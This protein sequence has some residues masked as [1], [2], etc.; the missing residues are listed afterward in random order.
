MMKG[1]CRMSSLP[2]HVP[3]AA[4]PTSHCKNR[5]HASTGCREV[6][7]PK[8]TFKASVTIQVQRLQEGSDADS[9]TVARPLRTGLFHPW[10]TL[11]VGVVKGRQIWPR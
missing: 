5:L 3:D 11:L 4:A 1:A 7:T 9:A 6:Q 10:M 2:S 8:E